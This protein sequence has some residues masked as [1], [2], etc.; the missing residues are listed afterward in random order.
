LPASYSTNVQYLKGVGPARATAL[1]KLGIYTI[2]DLLEHYPV[3][4]EDRSQTKRIGS[5]VAGEPQ[6]FVAT[7]VSVAES[8]PRRGLTITKVLVRDDSGTAQLVWFNQSYKKR[9]YLP[10]QKVSVYGKVERW[11]PVIQIKNPDVEVLESKDSKGS[12][13]I[14]PVYAATESLSQRWLRN[15][16]REALAMVPAADDLPAT[17]IEEYKLLDRR[18]ALVNIH[19]PATNELLVQ[20]R[21]RL[22]FEELFWLQCGLALLKQKYKA[23]GY[24]IKHGPDGQLVKRLLDNLPFTLTSDQHLAWQEIK[25]DMEDITPMQRL[26]QG[27]VGSGK[28]VVAA[29]AL[30]KT[31]ENGYQ[32]AFMAPTEILA[33]QHYHTLAPLVAPLGVRVA[34]LTGSLTEKQRKIVKDLIKNG[35]VDIVVG[36]HTLIQEDVEFARL[37]LAVTDEQHRFGVNQRAR[38]QAKGRMPDVLAMTATPIPRTMALTVY[39]DLDVSTIRQLPPGR[40]PVKTFTRGRDRRDKVYQF[41]VEEIRRGRQAYIVCPLV[42]E[43]E[44]ITAQSVTELYNEV[45]QT[46]FRDIPCG[47]VH[48]RLNPQDKEKVMQAFYQGEIKVLIATTVIEVGVNVPNA[49]I[50]VV[51]GADR[52]GLAQLHQLRGR[53]GRGEWQSYCILLHDGPTAS[54]PERLQ[55]MT[56]INDGFILAEKDLLLRG[57]GHLFG[58]RQHGLPDLKIADI[59]KDIDILLKARQAALKLIA[60]PGTAPDLRQ[61]VSEKLGPN[62]GQ[63]LQS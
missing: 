19:F 48:G 41:V 26:L 31:V 39:G 18:T 20:A 43:S 44:A 22:I 9:Q 13:G 58:T 29:L 35:S 52:F 17:V 1:A 14:L 56:E 25:A 57:P 47:V 53:V 60:H 24:G 38:L 11:G 32:G 7:V 4:Y 36:T 55:L 10:G 34:L 15:I 61:L 59:V 27:D 42:E 62:F 40:K 23:A 28:T 46:Y 30:A 12:S 50:M 37:G 3:R 63:I 45:S 8:R 51:E 49:S 2:G 54:P 16:V 5:L 33:E 21:Y 6:S